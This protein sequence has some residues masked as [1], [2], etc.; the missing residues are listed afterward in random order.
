M[1]E[2]YA[3]AHLVGL[4]AID[5]LHRAECKVFL[6]VV[7]WTYGTLYDVARLQEIFLDLLGR[8]VDVVG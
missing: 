8:Y 5:G 3:V 2:G 7:G 4:T 1:F 6:V